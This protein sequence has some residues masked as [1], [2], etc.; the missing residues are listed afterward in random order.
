MEYGDDLDQWRMMVNDSKMLC[1]EFLTTEQSFALKYLIYQDNAFE[2]TV[3]IDDT[4]FDITEID[5]EY[6]IGSSSTTVYLWIPYIGLVSGLF[7]GLM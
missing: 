3:E 6:N 7:H 2:I 5:P 1:I 4:G